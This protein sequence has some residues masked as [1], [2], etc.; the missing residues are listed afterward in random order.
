M[1]WCSSDQLVKPALV[2]SQNVVRS[3]S[4]T[5]KPKVP[6]ELCTDWSDSQPQD[7]YHT[8]ATKYVS[9]TAHLLYIEV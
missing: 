3:L 9:Q 5:Y 4:F 1:T 8:P 6:N 7:I 2:S